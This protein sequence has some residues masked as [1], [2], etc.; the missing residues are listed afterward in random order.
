MDGPSGVPAL[1]GDRLAPGSMDGTRIQ[2]ELG[3]ERCRASSHRGIYRAGRIRLCA[4]RTTRLVH[5]AT[6]GRR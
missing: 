6:N 5:I 2:P 1:L 4:V 3:R